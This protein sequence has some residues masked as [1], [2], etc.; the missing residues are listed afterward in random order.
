M[1]IRLFDL[2]RRSDRKEDG[3]SRALQAARV[4]A[5]HIRS[6]FAPALFNLVPVET[7]QIG[8]MAVDAH[9]RLYYNAGWLAAHTVEE[10]ASLLI[11][12]VSHLLRDHEARKKASGST[13]HRRWNTAG[14][15]EI[16]DDL[17]AEELPLPG[18]PPLP[19]KYGF[20]SGQSA[21]IYYHQLASPKERT[22]S[23]PQ[24]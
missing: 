3:Y 7:D 6:Y 10:N 2:I 5:A 12:E 17:Q 13:D 20:Q 24:S 19:S 11:H 16:N 15:C 9:W 8:S 21:E 18:D 23:E 4:R 22:A 1:T 14:D